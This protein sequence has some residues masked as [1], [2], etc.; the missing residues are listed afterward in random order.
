MPR[1]VVITGQGA[2]SSLGRSAA[3]MR[4][5]MAE[6]RAAMAHWRDLRHL[7]KRVDDALRF[8]ALPAPSGPRRG[9]PVRTLAEAMDLARSLPGAVGAG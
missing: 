7:V 5:A 8:L 6:G 1:R 4:A 3:D 9:P 2:F